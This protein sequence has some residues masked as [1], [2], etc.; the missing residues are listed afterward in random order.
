MPDGESRL[1]RWVSAAEK[2]LRIF[3]Y[4][5][6]NVRDRTGSFV[7][8]KAKKT[9]HHFLV[10]QLFPSYL[11]AMYKNKNRYSKT[12]FRRYLIV[13]DPSKANVFIID[14]NWIT[15]GDLYPNCS[16]F[17]ERHFRPIV[18]SIVNNYPYLNR[19]YGRDH[20]MMSVHDNGAFRY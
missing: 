3:I 8:K 12:D 11:K 17:I 5:V 14:H 9:H 13:N 19:S 1:L 7:M 4:P 20:F 6:P 2:Y 10:E 16:V 18:N 15:K